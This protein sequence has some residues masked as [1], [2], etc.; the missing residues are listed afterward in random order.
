MDTRKRNGLL[1]IAFTLALCG[2]SGGCGLH[3]EEVGELTGYVEDTGRD[4][5]EGDLEMG[6]SRNGKNRYVIFIKPLGSGENINYG[7]DYVAY[8]NYKGTRICYEWGT[9]ECPGNE[10]YIKSVDRSEFIYQDYKT[11]EI[12]KKIDLAPLF[13]DKEK[14]P[15][16]RVTLVRGPI[17]YQGREYFLLGAIELPKKEEDIK[18]AEMVTLLIDKETKEVLERPEKWY[19]QERYDTEEIKEAKI[20]AA[21]DTDAGANYIYFLLN[22]RERKMDVVVDAENYDYEKGKVFCVISCTGASLPEENGKLYGEFPALKKYQGLEE[23]KIDLIFFDI[24][25]NEE[26]VE[27]FVEEGQEISYGGITIR[28]QDSIDGKEHQINSIDEF[29]LYSYGG[30]YADGPTEAFRNPPP[31]GEWSIDSYFQEPD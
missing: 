18:T 6:Y 25:S 12:I 19:Y 3:S 28:A 5:E 10:A 21:W 8:E 17:S 4:L 11:G 27:M 1:A 24:P 29:Y 16:G 14:F 9:I 7:E 31:E 13:N 23:K 20:Q 15:Y 22:T 26:I 30:H 2:A